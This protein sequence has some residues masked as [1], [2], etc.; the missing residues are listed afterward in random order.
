MHGAARAADE[1]PEISH[2]A[3]HLLTTDLGLFPHEGHC[4]WSLTSLPRRATVYRFLYDPLGRI[5]STLE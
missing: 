3:Q 2:P 4:K 1:M 5:F